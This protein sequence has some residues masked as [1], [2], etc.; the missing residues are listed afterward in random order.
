MFENLIAQ[1]EAVRILQSD[2]VRGQLPPSLLFSGPENSGKLTAALETVRVL[3]CEKGSAGWNCLCPSCE[4]HRFLTH[5]DLLLLGP[6][7]LRAEILAAGELLSRNPNR[8]ARFLFIR[9][10]RKLTLRFSPTLY[11]GE[12]NRLSKAVAL[13]QSLEE[14]AETAGPGRENAQASNES[15]DWADTASKA[16]ALA[17]KLEALLP[18]SIPIFQIRAVERW[19]RLAPFGERKV[20]VIENAERM[21]EGARNALLKILE[22]PPRTTHFI[23]L[24]SRPSALIPTILSRVRSYSLRGRDAQAS[25]KVLA[26]VFRAEGEDSG[27]SLDAFLAARKPLSSE[28][29]DAWARRFLSAL[30]AQLIAEEAPLPP[31][32]REL[33]AK[34]EDARVS[35]AITAISAATKGFGSGDETLGYFFPGFLRSLAGLLRGVLRNPEADA[36]AADLLASWTSCLRDALLRHDAYNL[37]PTALVERMAQDMAEIGRSR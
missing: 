10:I 12:E 23:L 35:Q 14:I 15:Q 2:L 17:D 20:A 37:A 29:S 33:A 30:C 5:P 28:E 19:A 8:A 11:E 27:L 13:V 34:A 22:E 9:A 7:S 3:S 36:D 31:A 25:R 21:L 24:S 6:R 1:D 16:L 4:R 32:F 26:K 18:D